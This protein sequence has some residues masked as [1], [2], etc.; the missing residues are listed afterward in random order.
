MGLHAKIVNVMRQCAY[1]TKDGKNVSQNYTYVSDEQLMRQVNAALCEQG[2]ATYVTSI[3]VLGVETFKSSKGTEFYRTRVEA[4]FEL[5][6]IDSGES[7]HIVGAGEGSDT[8]DKSLYKALTGARKYA[9]RL[10]LNMAT[11]DDAEKDTGEEKAEQAKAKGK[12]PSKK[13]IGELAVQKIAEI[14]AA[15]AENIQSIAAVLKAQKS[16]F[17]SYE[18]ESL[19][20]MFAAKNNQ[21]KQLS[22]GGQK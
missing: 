11:G 7:R 22:I 18:W 16:T 4:V 3:R 20:S 9:W 12:R 5:V 1:A 10:T 15:T 6:D 8:S 17:T 21:L 2:I 13:D 14:N 19:S